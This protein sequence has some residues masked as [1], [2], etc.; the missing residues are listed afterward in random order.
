MRLPDRVVTAI[1]LPC[2]TLLTG[3]GCVHVRP[4]NTPAPQVPDAW[5]LDVAGRHQQGNECGPNALAIAL[6][7]SGDDL[8]YADLRQALQPPGSDAALTVDLLLFAR[9]RGFDAR[10]AAGAIEGVVAALREGL[11]V[12]LLLELSLAQSKR[13]RRGELWHYVVAYGYSARRREVYVH[14]GVGPKAISYE[15]L[16]RLWAPGGRWMM[17]LGRRVARAGRALPDTERW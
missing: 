12:I 16:G 11:P 8:P 2:V 6:R 14:S 7:A 17:T 15:R 4:W 9:R 1:L 3:G 13:A 5:L 10:F